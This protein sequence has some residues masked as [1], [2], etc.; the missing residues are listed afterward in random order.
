VS[1]G[2]EQ[3]VDV[4]ERGASQH[5]ERRLFMQLQAFG[6]CLDTKPL[7]RALEGAGLDA[8]L[9]QD[10]NDPRGVGILGMYE[11]PA[12]FAGPFREVLNTGAFGDLLLK[13]ELTMFGRTY[14]SGF[15]TE[16]E[17]WLLQRPRR[18][19]LN[20]LWPWGIWYPLRRNGAFARLTPQEQGA[21]IREHSVLGRAY[22]EA[23]LAHDVRLAC[24]G[25]DVHDND[26]IIGLCGRELHPLS[27]LVQ[28]MRKTAQTSQY[29]QTLGPFFVGHAIWQSPLR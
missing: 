6:G 7:V 5:S 25:L 19:V 11:D 28:A 23:D 12:F 14:A 20:P 27:H 13:P 29:L 3:R 26:F 24:H 9:Y 16:L 21:V 8:V 10:V 22:G 15:E 2:E 4:R 1:S 18:T 17:D